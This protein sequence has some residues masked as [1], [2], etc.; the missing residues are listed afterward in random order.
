MIEYD[1][2]GLTGNLRQLVNIRI[3][4]QQISNSTYMKGRTQ[5]QKI[6][7]KTQMHPLK[8]FNFTRPYPLDIIQRQ[9]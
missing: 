5:S 3:C 8:Y 1:I 4:P 7:S 9:N 6:Y 2:Y